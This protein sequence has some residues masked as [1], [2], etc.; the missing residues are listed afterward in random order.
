[1]T[2]N[3]LPPPGG[4]Y[5]ASVR[6]GNLVFTAGQVGKRVDGSLPDT[7]DEQTR[8]ALRNLETALAQ[9]SATL[10]DVVTVNVFLTDRA[11]FAAMNAIYREFFTCDPLPT[12]TT[13]TVTLNPGVL[14]EV[15]AQAVLD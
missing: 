12:R 13:V 3:A 1:M 4:P 6:R 8:V 7:F 5:S 10:A 11:D 2:D 15:N 9:Q 14:F